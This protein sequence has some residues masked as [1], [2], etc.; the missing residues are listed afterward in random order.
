MN[1]KICRVNSSKKKQKELFSIF[2]TEDSY[3]EPNDII[4]KFK[5]STI[6]PNLTSS[7]ICFVHLETLRLFLLHN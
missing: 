5:H 6:E 2:Q 7:T 4:L 1:I 3:M